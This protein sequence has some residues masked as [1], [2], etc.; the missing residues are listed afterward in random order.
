MLAITFAFLSTVLLHPS[1]ESLAEVQWNASTRKV[2]V[3]LRLR[4]ADEQ[5]LLQSV[6]SQ[7]ATVILADEAAL[8]RAGLSVIR[9]R[10]G[11]GKLNDLQSPTN[12]SKQPQG[13]EVAKRYQWIGR[14]SEGG[15]AWWFFEIAT[16]SGRPTHLR[17]TLF[18]KP[19]DPQNR[20]DSSHDHLHAMPVSTFLILADAQPASDPPA[21]RRS[22]SPRPNSMTLTPEHPISEIQW[23]VPAS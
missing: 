7:S 14:R 19:S 23:V 8:E 11:F 10:I 20:N 15:H 12:T 17:C 21:E 9:R 6:S 3:A 5:R 18:E 1:A 16:P 4:I 13:T 2:E 22:S